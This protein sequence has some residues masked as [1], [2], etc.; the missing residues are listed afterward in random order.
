M[1]LMEGLCL[2]TTTQL[3]ENLEESIGQL[4]SQRLRRTN[5]G[6]RSASAST[7]HTSDLEQQGSGSGINGRARGWEQWVPV[8]S[9]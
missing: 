5:G 2:L 8:V 7:L 1:S 3:K 9:Q 4:Q 6:V